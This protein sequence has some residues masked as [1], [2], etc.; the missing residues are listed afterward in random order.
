L[1]GIGNFAVYHKQLSSIIDDK[2]SS[3]APEKIRDY[4]RKEP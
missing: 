1:I 2:K 4:G 3:I